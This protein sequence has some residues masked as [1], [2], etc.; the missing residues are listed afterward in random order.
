[1]SV[2]P[3]TDA[4]EQEEEGTSV[5]D[6]IPGEYVVSFFNDRDRKA[7]IDLAESRGVQVIDTLDFGNAVR[8]RTKN[9]EEFLSL[10]E[11]GPTPVD[12]SPNYY[13]R[14]PE[15]EG[16]NP[17]EPQSGYKGFGSLSLAWLGV[18]EDNG[19][20]G[21]GVTVAILDTAVADHTA[22]TG[23]DVTC[24]DLIDVGKSEAADFGGHGTAV[25][26]LIVGVTPD[27]AGIAPSA[28]ILNIR[29]LSEDGVGDTFTLAKGIVEAVER[30]ADIIN[31]CL[32]TYGTSFI[33]EDAV[34]LAVQREVAL[35][36]ATGND[37]V[38]GVMYPAR[39][40]AVV[41][42]SAVDAAGRHAYFANRGEEV[43][44]AAPGIGVYAAWTNNTVAAFSGTSAGVPFVS[45]VLAVLMGEHSEMSAEAATEIVLNYCDDA[46]APGA[47]PA[48]GNGILN[49][50]RVRDRNVGGL[51]D[52]AIGNLYVLP[53]TDKNPEPRVV[54]YA[55]NRGTE[56]LSRVDLTV[57]VDGTRSVTSFFAINAGEIVSQEVV[58]DSSKLQGQG[59]TTVSCRAEAAH[60]SDIHPEKNAMTATIFLD[61]K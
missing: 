46:G 11:E 19:A 41:A 42:V 3:E 4:V 22:L 54:I 38:E 21:S 61:G 37:A 12:A 48:L 20:W 60:V 18:N 33:L 2:T 56:Q 47:D 53:A 24:V 16:K 57:E 28:R 31:M 40:D 34:E 7:F 30:E 25:A 6:A 8:I 50:G 35:V 5:R 49:V 23:K 27:V 10:K 32:G 26:S 44:L 36:A 58:L 55:Q 9:Y 13:V 59:S 29:V 45:G 39:Y 43:D 51:Y 1:V 17:L 15:E 52:I 14:T